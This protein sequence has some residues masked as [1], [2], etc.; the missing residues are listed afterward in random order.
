MIRDGSFKN[1]CRRSPEGLENLGKMR[2]IIRANVSEARR[3]H[4]RRRRAGKGETKRSGREPLR[5]MV[6]KMVWIFENF[7]LWKT[8]KHI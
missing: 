7:L 4:S 2:K 1:F 6:E 3:E 5:S 8:S